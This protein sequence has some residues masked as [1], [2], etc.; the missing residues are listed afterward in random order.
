MNKLFSLRL[1]AAVAL[2]IGTSTA[3]FADGPSTAPAQTAPQAAHEAQQAGP[4]VSAEAKALLDKLTAAYADAKNLEMA[5]TIHADFDVSGQKMDQTGK[6]EAIFLSPLQFRHQLQDDVLLG[7]DGKAIYIYSEKAKMYRTWALP[8]GATKL[9]DMPMVV[10]S[11]LQQQNPALLLALSQDAGKELTE[12]TSNVTLADDV[13]IEGAKCPALRITEENGDTTVVVDPQTSLVRRVV[14]DMKKGLQQRGQGQVN[15]A[16]LTFEYTKV[17]TKTAVKAEQF[18]W[19][20]PQDAKDAATAQVQQESQNPANELVGKPAPD[21]KLPSLDGKEVALSDL[22]GKVVV[23]DFWATWCGPCVQSLPHIDA[24]YQEKSPAG[25]EVFAVNLQEEKEKVSQFLK[26]H[27]LKLPV[28]LDQNGAVG[29]QYLASA[30][31]ETVV[32]GKDGNVA[33][34]FV[35]AGP[36]TAEKLKAAVET[37]MAAK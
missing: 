22:K 30:I 16:M 32:I 35:G 31:P 3:T 13:E 27:N 34:V 4:K 21:F 8:E 10:P 11:I 7:S 15:N 19:T 9:S 1:A 33:Q 23:L 37:A 28:L 36:D 12:H 14:V 20:P 18:A 24:L 6:F 26:D 2:T 25:L 5:G 29:Q 17:D